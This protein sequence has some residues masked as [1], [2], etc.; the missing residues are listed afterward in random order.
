MA[1]GTGGLSWSQLGGDISPAGRILIEAQLPAGA[2][3]WRFAPNGQTNLVTMTGR[4][5]A[6]TNG[7]VL[8]S[9]TTSFV[10]DD[11]DVAFDGSL[12]DDPSK[13][14]NGFTN[15]GLWK[16]SPSEDMALIAREG[17]VAPGTN[18]NAFTGFVGSLQWQRAF[19]SAGQM[20]FSNTD[21]TLVHNP[22]GSISYAESTRAGIWAPGT[23]GDVTRL[24]QIGAPAPGVSGA[25]FAQLNNFDGFN[26]GLNDQGQ[27][28]FSG[29]MTGGGVT[30][31]NDVGI[32]M[33]H[34]ST[35]V[36]LLLQEGA[37]TPGIAGG[38]FGDL[39]DP[40]I[41][42]AGELAFY[43]QVRS[44][45]STRG[46]LWR[47]NA[48]GELSPLVVTGQDAP[49]GGG[50]KFQSIS[51]TPYINSQGAVVFWAAL[52]VAPA[53][54]S[55][56]YEIG[57]W[58]ANAAAGLSA[59]Y[60]EGFAAPGTLGA[61]FD[62]LN[63]NIRPSINSQGDVLF[64]ASL[65]T[66]VGSVNSQNNQGVW[67]YSAAHHELVMLAR[68]GMLWDVNDDPSIED[69]RTVAFVVSGTGGGG[70]DGRSNGLS[71][72]GE[73]LLKLVFTDGTQGIFTVQVVPEPTMATLVLACGANYPRFRRNRR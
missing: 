29:R 33:S 49:V 13:G 32:W 19:N 43:A 51:G 2:G 42:G 7:A 18:G 71:D 9:L 54:N 41:N 25:A 23:A 69:W 45:T 21:G 5:A 65:K 10:N 67:I 50:L 59:I 24:A 8:S 36:E 60:R 72:R 56:A 1:P 68:T 15:E 44:N 47:A 73:A 63:T 40:A 26:L 17:F 4:V 64:N 11:G 28:A 48:V 58:S 52:G 6:G 55:S 39:L 12:V 66:G 38:V 70:S 34:G 37:V 16:I 46:S 3:V 14:V 57:L 53:N 22:D 27:T 35:G 31:S 61:V 20:I 62:E 30:T